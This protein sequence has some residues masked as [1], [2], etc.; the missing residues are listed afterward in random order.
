MTEL[1][2]LRSVQL[3]TMNCKKCGGT[4]AI[5]EHY[6]AD[7]QAN[8]G[9]WSCPYCQRTWSYTESGNDRLKRELKAAQN[10]AAWQKTLKNRANKWAKRAEHQRRGEKAAKTRIKNRVKNGVC[11]CCNR[12]FQNLMRHMKSQHPKWAEQH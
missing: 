7:R 2:L 8:G 4:Y 1:D 11:P 5:N 3:T 10:D 6:R 9:S 12:T